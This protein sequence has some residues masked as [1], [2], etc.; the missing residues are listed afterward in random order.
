MIQNEYRQEN[1]D[2]SL[3]ADFGFVNN[4]KYTEINKK[5]SIS[6]NKVFLGT[7]A[8]RMSQDCI[9]LHGGMGVAKEMSIGHYFARITTFC[10]LFGNADYH[11]KKFAS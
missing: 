2:S 10:S 1:K 4:F 5:K 7:H 8:K 6:L 3:I 9:Q 11:L